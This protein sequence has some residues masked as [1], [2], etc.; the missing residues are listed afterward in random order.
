MCIVLFCRWENRSI[1]MDSLKVLPSSKLSLSWKFESP[2]FRAIKMENYICDKNIFKFPWKLLNCI[3]ILQLRYESMR[4]HFVRA[5]HNSGR[6]ASK[7]KLKRFKRAFCIF[8]SFSKNIFWRNILVVFD[9]INWTHCYHYCFVK[10]F[11]ARMEALIH[12]IRYALCISIQH[13]IIFK[14]N[15]HISFQFVLCLRLDKWISHFLHRI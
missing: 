12:T 13:K 1:L 15:S 2:V 8:Q 10:I 4:M 11:I 5:V 7:M 14:C 9:R 6:K 3:L